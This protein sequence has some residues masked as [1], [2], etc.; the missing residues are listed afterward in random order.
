[1]TTATTYSEFAD[2]EARGVSP[3]YERL[4][5]AVAGDDEVLALLDRLPTGKRQPN[6][7]FSV[8]RFLGGPVDDPTA[9]RAYT[10]ANWLAIEAEMLT[11]A[12]QTNEIGRCALLL[13]VLA[14]LPQPLAL[15]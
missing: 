14:M 4:S 9:F 1:M 5:L 11:R 2:R 3:M 15:L 8:V 10:V 6:L 12:T 7:L 13:P